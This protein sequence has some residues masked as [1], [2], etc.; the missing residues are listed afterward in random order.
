MPPPARW[1]VVVPLKDTRDAKSRIRG[2]PGDRRRLAIQMARDTLCAIVLADVVDAVVVVCGR[3]EDRWS[4]RLPGVRV[5]A[6]PGLGLNEAVRAGVRLV[7]RADP[8]AN[9]AVLP[10]DL[11]YLRSAELDAALVCA[12]D[13][14]RAVVADHHGTGTTLLTARGGSEAE[15]RYGPHSLRRHRAAGAVVLS[16][17]TWSGLRRDVDD[18]ID[19]TDGPALGPRTRV[20]LRR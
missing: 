9:V 16:F 5:V 11:P 17:P 2:D 7:R 6:C 12:A 1:S 13:H 15:P 10:G 18:R 14:P 4:F 19:L 8:G 3:T 20:L